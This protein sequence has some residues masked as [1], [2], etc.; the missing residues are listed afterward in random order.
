MAV[1]VGIAGITGKFAR[2]LTFNLLKYPAVK[3][4]G[5]CRDPS[6]VPK[7]F[8]ENP[9]VT[10]HK[11]DAFDA[12]ALKSFVAGCDVVVCCYLGDDKLMTD[13]QKL[14]VDISEEAGVPR[15]V[16]SD[17]ALDYTKLELGQLFVKDPQI[18]VKEYLGTKKTIKGVHILV[19]AFMNPWFSPPFNVWDPATATFKYWG[20]GDE[21]WE[22][23]TY[24]N[25]AEFTAAICLDKD[26]VG[27]QKGEYLDTAVCEAAMLTT[28]EQSLV[29]GQHSVK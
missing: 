26:A 18:K 25:A 22:G 29:D 2:V 10:L 16:A 12:P 19:G 5:Y 6:K 23:T 17:W 27:I 14:L 21:V 15:Y 20:T 24:E 4:K 13:G 28:C 7:S 9:N 1:T 3:I 8:S 11:G